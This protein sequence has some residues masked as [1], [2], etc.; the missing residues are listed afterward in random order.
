MARR[1]WKPNARTWQQPDRW[2]GAEA[3]ARQLRVAPLVAQMLHNRGIESFDAAE[4][5]IKPQLNDLHDPQDLGGCPEGASRLVEAI[6]DGRKIV[7]YGDYDVDGMT[8]TAILHQCLT[9]LNANVHTYVPHRIEEGYGVNQE[10]VDALIDDG[11]EVLVTVDCGIRAIEPLAAAKARG[12]TVIVTDHHSP[13]ESLPDVDA[14]V[15]PTACGASPNPHLCGAGVAFKLAWQTAREV[16]GNHRVDKPMRDFLLD[17]TCLAALGTIADVVPLVGENR[18]LATFGLKGLTQSGHLGIRALL[19]ASELLETRLD[20]YHVGFVLAPRL[21]AAGRIGHARQAVDLLTAGDSAKA[22]EIAQFLNEQNTQRQRVERKITDAAVALA[23]QQGLDSDDARAIVLAGDDWHAGVIGIVAS[24]LV[25]RFY[26]PAALIAINDD[27]VGQGSCRSIKGFNIAEALDACSEH[28]ISFGG[29]AMAGGFRVKQENIGA[30]AQAF[31]AHAKT[32]IEPEQLK[33][34]LTLDAEARLSSLD[35][36]TVEQL[37]RM[38]PFGQS[39]PRPVIAV[40]GCRLLGPAKR[41]GKTGAHVS[42]VLGQ[43]GTS[44][45]AVGFGMGDLAD[46]LAAIREVDIAA[47]PVLNTF[48]GRTNVELHLCDVV[49]K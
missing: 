13:G 21:N 12:A 14:I 17:A 47:H 38:A 16:C 2:S 43:N 36:N 24:R 22:L 42:M 49:W 4:K 48:N 33:P 39:N 35:Y 20:A 34:V 25:D 23:T 11:A 37:E 6:R 7:I 46:A 40:R 29:H 9:M 15:H 28:L 32:A 18:V 26:R 19:E 10:A 31:A 1:A 30:F 44:M 3:L 27:G 41:M 45:R 5:F 8:G